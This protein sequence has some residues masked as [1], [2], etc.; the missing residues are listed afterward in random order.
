MADTASYRGRETTINALGQTWRLGRWTVD[1]IDKFTDWARTKLPDPVQVG[2]DA[3]LR[4]QRKMSQAQVDHRNKKIPD[5]EM[6]FLMQFYAQE[7]ER[8][9][10]IAMDKAASYLAINSPEFL[11]LL[12]HP[13]GT[14][15][16]IRLLCEA[17]HEMDDD[18]AFAIAAELP[19]EEKERAFTVTSGKMPPEPA[20]NSLAPA[21]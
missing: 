12:K 8:V 20:P 1:V 15:Q 14:A 3:C 7:Q 21:A 6:K 13:R 4:L 17:H 16:M 5:D 11:S 18:T 10:R 19:D 9:A 2:E